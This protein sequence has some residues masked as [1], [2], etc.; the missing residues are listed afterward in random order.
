MFILKGVKVK[1]NIVYV[2]SF[3]THAVLLAIFMAVKNK[4]DVFTLILFMGLPIIVSGILA[5]VGT[6]MQKEHNSMKEI[7]T[8]IPYVGINVLYWIFVNVQLNTGNTLNTIYETSRRYNSDM[9]EVSTNNS[10][11]SGMILLVLVSFILC[12]FMVK[13]AG[14]RDKIEQ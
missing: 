3:L 12:Y 11:V 8:V 6:K 13:H 7:P 1:K 5:F 14:K 4:L 2:I 10:P 9:I